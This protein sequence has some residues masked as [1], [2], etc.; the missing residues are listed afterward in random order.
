MNANFNNFRGHLLPID[1]NTATG[2]D[3]TYNLG[4]NDYRWLE[5]HFGI[6]VMTGQSTP[7][8]NPTT[9]RYKVY[10]KS[11]GYLYRLNSSGAEAQVASGVPLTTKGDLAVHDGSATVRFPVGTDGHILYADSSATA[12]VKWAAAPSAS[13]LTVRSVT[14]TDLATTADTVLILSGASFTQTLFTAVGNSG[15]VMEIIHNGTSLSQVYTL[16]TQSAQ[17]IGG[18]ASGSYVLQ[19]NGEKLRLISDGIN[20][21]ILDHK[22]E[23]DWTSYTPTIGGAGTP[24]GMSA[25]WRRVG[26]MLEAKFYFLP[27]TTST[28]AATVSLPTGATINTSKILGDQVEIVGRSMAAATTT[29]TSFPATSVGPFVISVDTGASTTVY[30]ADVTDKDDGLFTVRGGTTIWNSSGDVVSGY[31]RVPISGWQ[32]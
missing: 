17:T 7:A 5:S 6:G 16:A 27:G 30:V 14:T 31:F 25:F 1:P 32:P 8:A 28:D 29:Q 4:A 3:N 15:K 12:G 10:M 18:V 13:N 9:S 22:T 23:T 11:D 19:T 20:W 21:L 26:S 2:S 24:S